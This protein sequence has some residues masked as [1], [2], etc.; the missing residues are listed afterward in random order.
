M[1]TLMPLLFPLL[2]F[3]VSLVVLFG[4]LRTGVNTLALDVPNERSLHSK[5]VSRLGGLATIAGIS[6]ALV[7]AGQLTLLSALI[8][9]AAISFLDDLRGLKAGV[10][11]AVH[12]L[13]LGGYFWMSYGATVPLM[14]LAVLT[15]FAVWLTNLYNFMDGIDGLAGGMAVAGFAAYAAAF[16]LAGAYT[17]ATV[18][19][20]I[21]SASAAF[22]WFN[23]NPAK[24]YMGDAGSI[25]LGFLAAALGT[26]GWMLG[27]W[28]IWFPLLVFSAFIADA[29]I[30]LV[31]RTLRG[32]KVWLPHREHYYQK[33]TLIG[34][35]HKKTALFE[36]ALMTVSCTLALLGLS[37]TERL[38]WL[39][40][41]TSFGLYGILFLN[42]DLRWRRFENEQ[43]DSD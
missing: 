35:G 2:S 37:L 5:P 25:T 39:L 36:Y 17:L 27:A 40:I 19:L 7:W 10:R 34:L 3:S 15:I 31:K 1:V 42:I 32:E 18:A 33:L 11:L 29:T 43:I 8:A 6:T 38:Q 26:T 12:V 24:I 9:L 22:L 20:S 23:F 14:L 13:V 28:P 4:I 30:T 16:F 21:A 41:V